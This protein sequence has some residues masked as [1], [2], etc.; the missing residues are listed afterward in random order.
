MSGSL[1]VYSPSGQFLN[2]TNPFGSFDGGVRTTTADFNGD[3]TADLAV[4]TGPGATAEVKVI[5]GKTGTVLFDV[6][7]F[8]SF[9]GGVFVSA[10]DVTGDGIA[11]LVITPDLSGGPRVEVF[12]GGT[13]VRVANFFGIDDPNFRGGARAAAGDINGDGIADL[14]VSAGFGGGPRI[15]V[16]DGKSLVAGQFVHLV[17]DFFLF[18]PALRNGA[19]VAVGDV[20]GD[21]RADIIGGGGP[22]GGPRVLVVSGAQLLAGGATVAINAPIANFFAGDINN[23]GGIR[24]T[25][26]NLDGDRFADVVAGSG[27]GAGSRVT[28]FYGKD[29]TSSNFPE[30]FAFDAFPGFN[31]GVY[32]G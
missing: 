16:Y 22:G 29:F 7:P 28:G 5:D 20:D 6:F 23:R 32:V 25:A 2:S 15:S 17:P 10:G 21:G 4:G 24:V 3:G 14:V 30:A 1:K 12:S 27:A 31:G 19:Y 9:V 13:F 11:D 26:K 8:E 18:E